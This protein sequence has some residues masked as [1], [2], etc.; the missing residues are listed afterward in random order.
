MGLYLLRYIIAL[1]YRDKKIDNNFNPTVSIFI[2]VKN[3]ENWI[4][5]TIK[6]SYNTGYPLDKLEVIVVDDGST[7]NTINEIRRAEKDF[8]GLVVEIFEKNQGKR[9][10]VTRCVQIA[11]GEVYIMLDSDTFLEKDSVAYIVQQ[12]KDNRV[13]AVSGRTDVYNLKQNL[14]TRVQG[15]KY[16]VAYR[17]FKSFESQFG[18]V[19]CCPGCFSAYRAD[20]IKEII[21]EWNDKKFFGYRCVA[22]EDRALTTLLLK[23]NRICYSDNARAK[24]IV[25]DNLKSFAIQQKRWMRSWFRE[26]LFVGAFMWKKN[27]V[28]ALS[29]YVMLVISFFAPL[30]L[31]REFVVVPAM[32]NIIPSYY[33]VGLAIIIISQSMFCILTNKYKFSVYGIFFT[34]FY[35]AFL[36]WL[37][38]V[39]VYTVTSGNWGSR[40][41]VF[42]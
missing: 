10:A 7:D 18:A 30:T 29:F 26:S 8:P 24:T 33:Y 13:A 5:E 41:A 14:I 2:P 6:L 19:T 40:G 3:E 31:V 16:Y 11:T 25:P 23:N 21:D 32:L 34:L 1:F 42:K 17:L 12:F 36:I 9:S 38:P 20:K 37:I 15:F 28:P 4:Y 39:A 22:G 27:P 35:F